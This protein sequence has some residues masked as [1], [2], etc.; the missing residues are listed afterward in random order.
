[1]NSYGE[2]RSDKLSLKGGKW[3]IVNVNPENRYTRARWSMIH[4]EQGPAS[5]EGVEIRPWNIC[6]K[7]TQWLSMLLN[8]LAD[9]CIKDETKKGEVSGSNGGK[10]V[11]G[12]RT[13]LQ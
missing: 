3:F 10:A 6:F 2:L 7:A 13:P 12:Q 4:Q 9:I 11:G 8:R 5:R 1:M